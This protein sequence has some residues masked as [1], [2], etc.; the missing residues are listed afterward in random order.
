[1]LQPLAD[2]RALF[3][4][5]DYRRVWAIGGLSGVARWL[6]FVAIAIFAYELTHSPE[7]VALLAVLR[8]V[9]YVLLGF[10]MG[11]LADALDRKRLLLASLS[12]WL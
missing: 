10:V 8:M 9:P 4:H 2:A 5:A 6:E 11:A 7:L 3:A 1:M 12:S